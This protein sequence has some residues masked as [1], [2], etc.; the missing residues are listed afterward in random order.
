VSREDLTE[1][2]G[3]RGSLRR[4]EDVLDTW[5]SSGL[6]PFSTL[7]WPHTTPELK[8][9]YPTSCLVTAY[10]ILF[11]WV[12]RMMMLGLHVME[13]VPFR[14]V[15]IHA[16]VRD[17]EGQKMS[18]SRGNVVDPLDVME[19]FG[20]DALRFTLAALAA[21]GRE[22]RLSNERIEGYRNFANK[23]WN[24][25]RFVLSNLDGHRPA[26][27][28]KA[29]PTLA[30]RW[31]RSR[32]H[33]TIL[34]TRQALAKYRYNDA[35]SAIYQFL[36]H[37]YCDWYLEWSKLTLYR[38]EDPAAR[39]RTQAT[40]VEVL[41]TTLRLLHPFMPFITEE[42]W[43][44]LPKARTAPKSIMIARYPKMQKRQQDAA[45]EADIEPVMAVISGIRSIR[46]EFQIPPSRTLSVVV[47]PTPAAEPLLR[48]ESAAIGA[49][50]KA[51]LRVE[52]GAQRAA[53]AVLK[54]VEGSEIHVSLAGVIDV[55]AERGR[56]GREL[57]KVEEDLARTEAKLG[58]EDFR[59]RAPAEVVAREE[60]RR[61]EQMA[62]L[63][64]LREGLARLDALDAR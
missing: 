32:L 38:G 53:D 12:A 23:L 24:A 36:W 20:T 1:C 62:L 60:S 28:R 8:T 11:F 52:P 22:I 56:L 13:E 39:A 27:A 14:D 47:K 6:W 4:D 5:F 51:D 54:V 58:R 44:R 34:E 42:I 19:H 55:A 17:M 43:Q 7:G 33:R 40:L 61:T 18:K 45:A 26:L 29:P 15:Y 9:F 3:C 48:G 25:A 21:Q 57:R 41:E 37:D 30:E 50:A 10:D 59:A 31:I 64:T 46:S 35:A 16:L 2:P 49:L 63:A